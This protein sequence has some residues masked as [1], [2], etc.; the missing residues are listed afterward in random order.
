M[1]SS[2]PNEPRLCRYG[3][4]A[5]LVALC[6]LSSAC[7]MRVND[8]IIIPAD[9]QRS[10]GASTVNGDVLVGENAVVDG[11]RLRSVNGS[12]R[13]DGGAKV[14]T[15]STVNGA[16]VVGADAATGG[17]ETVNGPAKCGERARV[18]GDIQLVNGPV[19]LNRGVVVEGDVG[20]VNG[21]I[22]LTGATVEGDVGNYNGGMRI[23]DGSRVKGKLVVRE[24]TPAEQGDPPRI[25]IGPQSSIDGKLE[26]ERS[27]ELYVHE[28]ARI[29]RVTGAE[30]VRYSD[31]VPG[32]D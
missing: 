13:I 32:D 8:D 31:V 26:F 24:S 14:G 19:T 30:P 29:G 22:H 15:I 27:V 28:S 5:L 25:V 2:S 4:A 6:V 10:S 1:T 21:H 17:I 12:V 16:V 3:A 20:T 18:R 7:Q 9:S 23:T 11:G